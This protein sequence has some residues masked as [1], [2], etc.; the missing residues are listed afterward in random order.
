MKNLKQLSKKAIKFCKMSGYDVAKV[1][2]LMKTSSFSVI[3][4]ETQM[5]IIYEG[6][7]PKYP[8]IIFNPF[9]HD[10]KYKR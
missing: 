2:H 6:V 5:E 3:R 1:K 4:L 10:I 9:N 8:Y 7:D